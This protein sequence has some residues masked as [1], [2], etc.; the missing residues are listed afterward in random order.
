M[1]TDFFYL[2]RQKGVPV[3]VTEWVSFMEA[4][5]GGYFQSNLNHLYYIGRAFLVKSEA[6]YDMF[7]L[8]FQ[9]YFGGIKTE[10]LELERVMDWLENPLNRLPKLSPEEM[11]EFQKK[12]EEFRKEHDMDEL[13]RQ[14]RE[15]LKEQKERHDGGGKWIGT[16]GVSPFGAYGYHPG[17]IRVGG[18]SWM[19]SAAKVAGER[20]FRNYRNDLILDVRQTK[21]AL[22]KLREL[23]REG[24]QEELDIP[25]TVDKTAKEGGEIELVFNRSRENTVR[26]ILLMDTGGSMLP[27]T[28]L[29]ERLFSAAS[30]M[31]HFK[32]FRYYFFHNCIYQDV[33]E[34]IGNYK[35]VPTEKLFSQFHKGYKVVLVGDARMAY[36]ELFDINGCID[37]FYTNDRPAIE[38]LIRI[39]EH[40]PHSVW[41]N[42]T[43]SNFWGHY[44]VDTVGKIFPMFELTIDGLKD[45][46]KTLTSKAKPAMVA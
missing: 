41:L 18:E 4:L 46:I 1:F 43:H 2:L 34:D 37:Y 20:R 10:P 31:E 30:Q 14:F 19:Q 13:M 16:G 9:E 8:A 3:T 28:E 27:Y 5:H 33:Y 24:A 38:W 6:Y 21:M 12:L 26:L 11:A 15:R 7:D 40:F 36:S 23:K 29:C 35:R 22:K 44:T 17:G 32:E 45:A 42:P 39:K 25:E